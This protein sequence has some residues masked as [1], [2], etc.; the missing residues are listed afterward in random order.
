[1]PFSTELIIERGLWL[2]SREASG[3]RE[4]APA[5]AACL[6]LPPAGA[7]SIG[8]SPQKFLAVQSGRGCFSFYHIFSVVADTLFMRLKFDTESLQWKLEETEDGVD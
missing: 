1:M 3:V 4:L 2:V 8:S 7:S 5:L 6:D